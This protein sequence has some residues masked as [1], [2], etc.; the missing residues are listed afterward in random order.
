MYP[1]NALSAAELAIMAVVVVASLAAWLTLVL[2]ADRQ[3]QRT[4]T[5]MNTQPH[6]KETGAAETPPRHSF[7]MLPRRR[8]RRPD[9]PALAPHHGNAGA[10]AGCPANGPASNQGT[11]RR[12]DERQLHDHMG[13]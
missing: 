4:S 7:L 3:P 10:R 2:R 8:T 12:T 5:A 6:E 13:A 1:D 9:P 11:D